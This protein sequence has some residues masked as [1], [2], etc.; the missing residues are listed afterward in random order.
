MEER[1]QGLRQ[2]LV[3]GD[4]SGA[5]SVAPQLL[6]NDVQTCLR[7]RMTRLVVAMSV[8]QL[9]GVLDA[10]KVS[11]SVGWSYVLMHIF[12]R[13]YLQ[14]SANILPK[15]ME[16]PFFFFFVSSS[17]RATRHLLSREV[18]KKSTRSIVSS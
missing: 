7:P 8:K 13:E 14:G 15:K 2:L 4:V 16:E 3:G 5:V 11:P 10:D 12:F 6:L 18:K 17:S 1:V 9:Q